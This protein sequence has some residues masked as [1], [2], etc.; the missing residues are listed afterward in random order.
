MANSK[1]GAF[2]SK[3]KNMCRGKDGNELRQHLL[4]EM[5]DLDMTWMTTE[6][7]YEIKDKLEADGYDI[8]AEI[9]S[10]LMNI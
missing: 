8:A 1:V 2:V 7:V 4:Y 6:D 9:F 3:V 10:K 5:P